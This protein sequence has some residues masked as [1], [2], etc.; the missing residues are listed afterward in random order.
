M[1]KNTGKSSEAIWE[2][3]WTRLGKRAYF[4]RIPDAAEHF[5][6]NK[7]R[8][9]NVRPT[10]SD[11]MLTVD[12]QTIY[13]EV[14]STQ[15]Q[16]AFPFSLLKKGQTAAAPQVLS[17]GGQYHVFVHNLSSD[18]WYRIPFQVIQAVKEIGKSSI[19]WTELEQF[20]WSLPI[21]TSWSTSKRPERTLPIMA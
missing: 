18:R 13:S 4:Y 7:G 15:N 9:I 21:S 16:T 14:K 11:Y 2:L 19:P 6:R 20:S 3:A 17:A 10:P 12:G 1:A 8:V 5:G